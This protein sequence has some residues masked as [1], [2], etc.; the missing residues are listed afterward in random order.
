MAAAE[1]I[2]VW[3]FRSSKPSTVESA[4]RFAPKFAVPAELAMTVPIVT[5]G[6]PPTPPLPPPLL[7]HT[8]CFKFT[9]QPSA[10]PA[11]FHH[12]NGLLATI[13]CPVGLLLHYFTRKFTLKFQ[14]HHLGQ[15]EHDWVIGKDG[16]P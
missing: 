14:V 13:R 7:G 1:M 5:V 3:D 10:G 15:T 2:P 9:R 16:A 4:R 12:L 11:V 8:P 6:R